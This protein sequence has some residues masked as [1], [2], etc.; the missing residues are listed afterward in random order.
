MTFMSPKKGEDYYNGSLCVAMRR[1]S[2]E[3]KT[4]AQ[5]DAIR[6]FMK[7][8]ASILFS[9]QE[10]KW[11]RKKLRDGAESDVDLLLR[12]ATR[13]PSFKGHL[14]ALT[15]KGESTGAITSGGEQQLRLHEVLFG[16]YPAMTQQYEREGNRE[17][18]PEITEQS[19][20]PLPP[21]RH[22]GPSDEA[23]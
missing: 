13:P 18:N 23:R 10:E 3:Q 5:I 8:A 15:T 16:R 17:V 20:A 19:A 22:S 2:R 6:S 7:D 21:A 12:S 9:Y 4:A 11:A 14:T 1:L